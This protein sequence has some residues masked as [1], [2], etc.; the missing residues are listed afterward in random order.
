MQND[1]KFHFG[2]AEKEGS[3]K[4]RKSSKRV[5]LI[6]HSKSKVDGADEGWAVGLSDGCLEGCVVGRLDG[7]VVGRLDGWR[8][9]QLVG[10]LIG[11]RVG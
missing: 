9:G 2:V 1:S 7:C 5:T 8:D 6:T 4:S 11:C 10:P 3:N